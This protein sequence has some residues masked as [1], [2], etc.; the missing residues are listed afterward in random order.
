MSGHSKWSQ[1]KR[2]KGIS[3]AQ[4]AVSFSRLCRA[5]SLAVGEGGGSTDVSL[6]SR[7]RFAL[8]MARAH[9]VPKET[10]ERAIER[11][12]K[13]D[14]LQLAEIVYEAFAPHGVQLVIVAATDKPS[15]TNSDVSLIISRAGGKMGIS[16]SVTHQFTKCALLTCVPECPANDALELAA[17]YGA[18]DIETDD[19]QSK[20]LL[21]FDTMGRVE[22]SE[23]I[24]SVSLYYKSNNQITGLATAQKDEVDDVIDRLL[25]LDDVQM[26]FSNMQ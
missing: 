7:L 18:F 13:G 5:I 21:P 1:I 14:G 20:V 19:L 11:G 9:H 8:K 26:V 23:Y 22:E 4:K 6:N 17:E 25:L 24:E 10:I 2:Q 3:D 16:G 15:R 12:R